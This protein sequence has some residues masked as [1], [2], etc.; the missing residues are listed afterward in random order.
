M[1]CQASARRSL[2]RGGS[3]AFVA[4]SEDDALVVT[5][6]LATPLPAAASS[7]RGEAPRTLPATR[8]SQ[9]RRN[10]FTPGQLA[11]RS[12]GKPGPATVSSLSAA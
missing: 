12:S 7:L 5:T 9:P 11:E 2:Q 6:S 3:D 10:R 1:E 8:A 4:G